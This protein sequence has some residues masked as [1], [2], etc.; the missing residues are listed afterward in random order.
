MPVSSVII[1][2]AMA[3]AALRVGHAI[4]QRDAWLTPGPALEEWANFG[5][6]GPPAG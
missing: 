5:G 4:R 6:G 1:A 2:A 3:A